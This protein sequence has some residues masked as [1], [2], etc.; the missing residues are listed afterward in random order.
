[1]AAHSFHVRAHTN[2]HVQHQTRVALKRGVG[3]AHNVGC[4]LMLGRVGVSG[5]DIFVLQGFEL[6]LRAKFVG[7]EKLNC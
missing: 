7:L 1:M 4:P 6:L 5:A 3:V 2:A